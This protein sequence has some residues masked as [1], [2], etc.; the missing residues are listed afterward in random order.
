MKQ[1]TTVVYTADTKEIATCVLNIRLAPRERNEDAV[2]LIKPNTALLTIS[3]SLNREENSKVIII[4]IKS[5]QPHISIFA[6]NT[7]CGF[8]KQVL[9]SSILLESIL[10][11]TTGTEAILSNGAAPQRKT[12]LLSIPA[13]MISVSLS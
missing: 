3:I 9:S 2:K 13:L 4:T 12:P 1:A 11:S 7:V 5:K 6:E 8:I 10:L